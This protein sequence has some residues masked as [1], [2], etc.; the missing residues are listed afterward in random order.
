MLTK[1]YKA[2]ERLPNVPDVCPIGPITVKNAEKVQLKQ[3]I[4]SEETTW[5]QLIHR[6]PVMFGI[7]KE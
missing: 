2:D 5:P 1:K 3:D 4:I 6:H 7:S